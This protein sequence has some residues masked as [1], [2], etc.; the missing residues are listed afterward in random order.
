[1]WITDPP[2]EMFGKTM[3]ISDALMPHWFEWGTEMPMNEVRATLDALARRDLPPREAKER[4]ARRVVTEFHSAAAAD[5]AARAFAR[6]FKDRQAPPDM[7]T[8]TIARD[9]QQRVG[10]V[11]VLLHLGVSSKSEARRLVG[12]RGVRVNEVVVD[13]ATTLPTSEEAVVRYGARK[14]ARIRWTS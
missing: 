5:E 13:E 9:G 1:V 7:P 10:I 4:L 14:F 3:S 12:Q 11:D 2:S 8:V 6:Q